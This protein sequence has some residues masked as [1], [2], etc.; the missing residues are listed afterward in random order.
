MF[1]RKFN[2]GIL[3]V[4]FSLF[5]I[6]SG[7]QLLANA[8]IR[9]SSPEQAASEFYRWYLQELN[10]ER[11]PIKQKA[12]MSGYV[13]R[14]LA[15]WVN[16]KAYSGWGADYF[17]DAQNFDEEWAQTVSASKPVIKGNNA[18]VTITLG[19][20]KDGRKYQG[21]GKHVLRL[22]MVNEAGAWKIDRVNNR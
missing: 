3:L 22:K 7:A 15:T 10:Q 5:F 20:F 21:M 17:I 11:N 13:S 19:V 4:L 14:R 12:K 1:E 6:S 9:Q 18:S 8:A 2:K 16:S